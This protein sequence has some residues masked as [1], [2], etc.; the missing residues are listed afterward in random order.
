M[1]MKL[2]ATAAIA[3]GL[4]FGMASSS[5]A[6]TPLVLGTGWLSDEVD[7]TTDPSLGSAFTVTLGAGQAAQ[8]SISDGFLHGDTYTIVLNG[9]DVFM[10]QLG[11]TATPFDNNLGPAAPFYAAD[12]LDPTF[13]HFALQFGPGSYSFV[14]TGD[15]GGGC[16]AGFGYRLDSLGVPEPAAWALMLAGFGLVGATLRSGRRQALTA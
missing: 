1:N 5:F 3:A 9:V 15:C 11:V 4:G 6:D 10:S 14:V 16:P 2:F 13:S 12:W 7:N 8:F